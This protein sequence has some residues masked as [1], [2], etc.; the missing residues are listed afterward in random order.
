MD[1]FKN[2]LSRTLEAITGCGDNLGV[3]CQLYVCD[4]LEEQKGPIQIRTKQCPVQFG[5]LPETSTDSQ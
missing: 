2:T 4:E 3:R 5:E 1:T